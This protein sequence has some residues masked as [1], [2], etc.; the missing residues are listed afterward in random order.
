MA[1]FRIKELCKEKGI[2]LITLSEMVAISQPSMSLIANGKQNPSIETLEKIAAALGVGI[3]ELFTPMD[4][5]K[6]VCPNCGHVITLRID[7]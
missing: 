1:S 4:G 6:V 2:T 5:T 7:E 3:G